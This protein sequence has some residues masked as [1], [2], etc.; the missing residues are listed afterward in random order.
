MIAFLSN[1]TGLA[2]AAAALILA[3]T[4]ALAIDVPS[5]QPVELHE[6]LVE[7][8]EAET[9]LRFRFVTPRIARGAGS[10]SY[11]Q[12]EPDMTHLCTT[13]AIPYAAEYGLRSDVI[14]VSFADRP[15]EF[16]AASPEATQFFE[17]YR[18]RDGVCIWEGF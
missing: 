17:A 10:I 6:V 14:V 4:S 2:P 15:T 18:P 7:Q 11:A 12:A 16:G 8:I 13:L 5:G 3:A 1:K 9:W